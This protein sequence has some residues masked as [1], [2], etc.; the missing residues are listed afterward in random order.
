[1]PEPA[2]SSWADEI[3]EGDSSTLPP[4]S[5][6]V[7]GDTKVVTE[8]IFNEDG[9]KM[10]VVRTYK[11][12]KKMVPK[13][14]AQRR[15]WAKFGMS[16]SD[17][18]GPNPQTTV[19]AEEIWMNFV[20]N[21]DESE[22]SQEESSLDKLKGVKGVVKCRFCKEDHWTTQ[23][24]YKD[25]LGPL[26]ETLIGPGEGEEGGAETAAAAPAPAGGGG[27]GGG[28]AGGGKYV[29]PSRRGMSEA[30]ARITGDSMP[31][32]RREDTAAIRVSNLSENVQEADLQ[33]LF[34]PFGN[35]ARI[36]LAKDKVTGQCKG[37][38]FVNYYRK[39]DAAKAIATL[40]GYGYDYLILSVEW[41]KPALDR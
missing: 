21:K 28:S 1:M 6:K 14:V 4:P 24:P 13:S 36:F 16:K 30:Q 32:R 27:G 26:R 40:N 22:K 11:I 7:K 2:A 41:A 31:D 15:A 10:R 5:E 19:V 3:E 12:E 18:A 35:I 17:K 20:A 25:T 23:C 9:K 34:K 38:A 33:E 39:E 29:P 37:F 8:Y